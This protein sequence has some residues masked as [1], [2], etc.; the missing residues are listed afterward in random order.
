[1][2]TDA[3]SVET[4]SKVQA[5]IDYWRISLLS[6]GHLVNDLYG[7]LLTSLM[8]YLILEGAITRSLAGYILLVYLVGSSVLQPIFGLLAD[9]SGRRF[10]V[11][12]GPLW[13]GISVCLVG[14]AGNAGTLFILA[15]VA[16][17]GTAAFHPQAAS[18]VNSLAARSKGRSMSLFSMGGNLGFAIGPLLAA[19]IAVVGL[20]WTPT[21]LLPCVVITILLARHVTAV[22][23][24]TYGHD[25]AG[26]G[27]A[28]RAAWQPLS[29]V[30]G[31]IA[32]R[33]A[34][35]YALI[36]LLP[37][38]YHLHGLS[39]EQGSLAAAL[40][41]LSGA[42]GGLL[43]GHI[44]DLYGRRRVVVA[45]L[46]A[47]A[48]LLLLSVMATGPVVWL[49]LALAGGTLL[50]SNSVTVVQGQELLPG[51]AGVASGLT[52]G[53]AFGLS[54][55]IGSGFTTLSDHIGVVQTVFLVPLLPVVA[56]LFGA[57]VPSSATPHVCPVLLAA[58]SAE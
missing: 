39:A 22:T 19:G 43:G 20:H 48:P 21:M 38:Y 58:H 45:T 29:F 52:L 55:V 33:S 27:K 5:Q 53:I 7:N 13:V 26:I 30:V 18:M 35:Q 37:L 44:S 46:L 56:A 25:E 17:V 57:F 12:V 24:V 10:F 2:S 14:W 31:V 34:A 54:G 42:F 28:A 6:A 1:M 3:L 36:I 23:P 8:P 16:G 40:L 50:A 15:A 9:R 49:L 41:S 32:V 51:N 47:S 11:I 4:H